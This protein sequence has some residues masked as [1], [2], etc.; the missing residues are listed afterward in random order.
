MIPL[1]SSKEIEAAVLGV[2]LDGRHTSSIHKA[3]AVLLSP[4]AFVTR[5][6]LVV[7]L[8]CVELDDQGIRVEAISVAERLTRWSWDDTLKRMRAKDGRISDSADAPDYADS[9]LAG[10]G[11]FNAISDIAAASA[12]AVS[13][14]RNVKVLWDLRG[15]R[16]LIES[17]YGACETA[18]QTP[19]SLQKCIDDASQAILAVSRQAQA[20]DVIEAPAVI[21]ET[22]AEMAERANGAPSGTIPTGVDEIDNLIDGMRP[23]GMYILAARPGAGKTTLALTVTANCCR[24]GIPVLFVSLEVDRT[25]LTRKLLSAEAQVD[26][27]DLDRGKLDALQQ[28]AVTEA[29]A[30]IRKWPLSVYDNSDMTFAALRSLVKKRA[31]ERPASLVIIDH[32]GLVAR[33][34]QKSSEYEHISEISRAAKVLAREMR[35]PVLVL[36]QMSRDSEKGQATPREPRMSDLRGSGTLEQD[37]DAICFLHRMEG[38]SDS[39]RQIKVLILKNRFGPTGSAEMTFIPKNMA[40]KGTSHERGGD[41]FGRMQSEPRPEE[42]VF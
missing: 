9:A 22:L 19:D 14:D 28:E 23:G 15:K 17:L 36:T 34:D 12:T 8:A 11:G 29:A 20:V 41:R 31:L 42:N 32:L 18:S 37:A 33:R 2:L 35:I 21:D 10:L 25:D 26:F 39:E 13:L 30:A 24:A 3:R 7:W 38:G 27:R 4:D 6:H 40:F 5:D 1:P 16:Q